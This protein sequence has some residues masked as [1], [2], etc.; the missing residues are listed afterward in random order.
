MGQCQSLFNMHIVFP[1]EDDFAMSL[2][3]NITLKRFEIFSHER[4][5][6]WDNTDFK[7]HRNICSNNIW[8]YLGH[9]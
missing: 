9:L 6:K 3:L 8:S 7:H 2:S 4:N 1:M 5:E